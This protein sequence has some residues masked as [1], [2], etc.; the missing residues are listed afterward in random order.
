VAGYLPHFGS[1]NFTQ[2]PVLKQ[3]GYGD[4]PDFQRRG[5]DEQFKVFHYNQY[6]V[7]V[8]K[9]VMPYRE[10]YHAPQQS[11]NCLCCGNIDYFTEPYCTECLDKK[12][13]LLL[14]FEGN[15]DKFKLTILYSGVSLGCAERF[16]LQVAAEIM[17]EE[18][19][20]D[21]FQER[22][23]IF[24][25]VGVIKLPQ[26][27]HQEQEVEGILDSIDPTKQFYLVYLERRSFVAAMETS[28]DPAIYNVELLNF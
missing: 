17:T 15:I 9:T 22:F 14:S 28:M 18:E 10:M 27:T 6:D 24:G 13:S 7:V 5:A 3:F 20:H 19:Y 16:N 11:F 8:R 4:C 25:M 2:S 23:R 12:K 26:H 21:R 1:G